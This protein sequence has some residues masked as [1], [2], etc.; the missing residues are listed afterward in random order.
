[1]YTLMGGGLLC[2]VSGL[3]LL[4]VATATDFWMQYRFSGSHANQG[5]WRYCINRKCHAHTITVAFWDATRAFMILSILACFAGIILGLAAFTNSSK[6]SRIRTAG[7]ILVIAGFFALL[8]LAVYTGVTV[9]FFGKRYVD[10]RFSWSYILG[11][12][13][14]ILT[15]S[16]GIFHICAYRKNS[17]QSGSTA[18]T[19]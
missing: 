9:N 13:A 11:W 19:S 2:A 1:M 3:V 7:V 14:I 18:V 4:I 5:L 8:A 6:F 17:N 16:A 10:W 15:V 12:V